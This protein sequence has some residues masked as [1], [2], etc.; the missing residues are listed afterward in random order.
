MI[1][2]TRADRSELVKGQ[3]VVY[4]YH[5]T[6]DEASH[7]ADTAVFP[8]C[9][10]AIIELKNLVRM[11][12]NDF[13]ATNIK[14]TADHGFVYT[15]EQLT[16]EQKFDKS[17][18][19][20]RMVEYGRRYAILMKGKEVQYL[21]KVHL[22]DESSGFDAYAPKGNVRIKLKG[23]GLNFVHGGTS[24]QEMVVPLIEYHHLRNDSI[25]YQKNKEKY[26]TKPAEVALLSG[27]HKVSNP[28]FSLSFYQKE[29][30]GYN[31]E[32]AL[33]Y[34]YF[35]DSNGKKLVILQRLL[36]TKRM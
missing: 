1:A 10:S 24:L 16:E 17:V 4:I 28:I 6:I 35:T 2:T 21:Q 11:L 29:A 8:A 23:S 31:V 27:T 25:E 5:D 14:I 26:D 36:R 9:D 32:A 20:H 18:F 3:E 22:F 33:Y 34:V 12:V 30:V 15:Y 7:T 19:E 13:S